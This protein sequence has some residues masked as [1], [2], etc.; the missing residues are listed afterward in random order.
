MQFTAEQIAELLGGEVDGDPQVLVNDLS[1][2]EEAR[3]GTLT[4]LANPIYTEFIYK[5]TA[6]I[7]RQTQTK[8]RPSSASRRCKGVTSA[9]SCSSS[10]AIRPNSV[11]IPVATTSARPLPLLA[12][13]PMYS[14][15]ARSPRTV[16][17]G[18]CAWA[19]LLT[20]V[21]SPVREAS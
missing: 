1:K 10:P 11:C 15:F 4:F 21:D 16:C 7:A 18:S 3:G 19:S 2:I 17:S 12:T 20:G 6:T 5:T 14:M 9:G 8:I 13:V